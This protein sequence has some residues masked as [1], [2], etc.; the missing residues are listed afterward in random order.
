MLT[1]YGFDDHELSKTE[2]ME[3][4]VLEIAGSLAALSPPELS[5]AISVC[6]EEGDNHAN[7]S[8]TRTVLRLLAPLL[9]KLKR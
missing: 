1:T 9:R 2:S 5:E 7:P 6:R 3:R 8:D 4:Y